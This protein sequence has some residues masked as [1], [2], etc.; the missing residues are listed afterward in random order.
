GEV[1]HF[2]AHGARWIAKL[3]TDLIRRGTYSIVARD[4]K[5]GALGVAVQS[6]WFSVGPIV[7]WARPGVGAV[8]TQA[9][10]EVSYGP[11]ALGLLAGGFDA[12]AALERLTDEDP[13]AAGR[14]V[15]IV[16]AEGR[17]A[18]HTGGSC[19]PR[20]GHA[21]GAACSCQANI[22][23]SDEVWPAMREAF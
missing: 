6:H 5:T 18:V 10:A 15:A 17:I 19:I 8:A 7:P 23:R 20:A 1:S 9:N 22:M 14:Q 21:V 4:P 13:G 16:D 12:T 11:R 2:G 3:R